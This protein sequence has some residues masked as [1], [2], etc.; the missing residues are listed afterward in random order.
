[1]LADLQDGQRDGVVVVDTDRLT[2]TPA[3]LETFIDIADRNRVAL[4]NAAGHLDLATSDGRF[5]ARIMGVVA[6][7]ESEKK[8][9]RLRRQ[10]DQLAAH[11]R[12]HPGPRPFGYQ[13]GGEQTDPDEAALIAAAATAVLAGR[14]I[15]SVADDWNAAGSRPPRAGGGLSTRSAS[16]WSHPGSPVCVSIAVRWSARGCGRRSLT[17]RLMSGWWRWPRRVVVRDG[18]PPGCCRA[19]R[20]ARAATVGG[21]APR[22]RAGRSMRAAVSRA[23]IRR[24]GGW[25]SPQIASTPRSPARSLPRWRARENAGS[26]WPHCDGLIWPHPNLV[27]SLYVVSGVAVWLSD[28]L[29]S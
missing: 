4:A 22:R 16:C 1:M 19:S 27:R 5:R 12:P 2:R 13:P 9:E 17:G 29:L 11:G 14:S 28:R 24:A 8:S 23:V 21:A 7:L 10:R 15:R 25:R 20:P 6:R 3:E 26:I 18:R